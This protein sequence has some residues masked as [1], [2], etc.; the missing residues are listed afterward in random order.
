MSCRKIRPK[1]DK[2]KLISFILFLSF[3]S[4]NDK[5]NE[6]G[7]VFIRT[8]FVGNKSVETRPGVRKEGESAGYPIAEKFKFRAKV[9]F[10]FEQIE[11]VDVCF[12]GLHVQE[13]DDKCLAPN[14]RRVYIGYLDSVK[15]FQPACL[16]T[17]VYHEL[18]MGKKKFKFCIFCLRTI[19]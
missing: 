19:L 17:G 1:F 15:F 13:Y 16:R 4:A 6:A 3:S 8:V 2:N 18:I 14:K 5:N 10:A 9:L 11:G 12:F 7:H